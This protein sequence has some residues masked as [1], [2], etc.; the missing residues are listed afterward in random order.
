MK[1]N[2]PAADEVRV[3]EISRAVCAID[4]VN[5]QPLV[6]LIVEVEGKTGSSP[7]ST[8]PGK[9][10]NAWSLL[11]SAAPGR[12]SQCGTRGFLGL[13]DNPQS[14]GSPSRSARLMAAPSSVGPAVFLG[15]APTRHATKPFDGTTLPRGG[16]VSAP[17]A[18]MM[19]LVEHP[20][21]P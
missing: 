9:Y 13:T 15:S 20:T 18:G 17:A 1:Y 19:C 7:A 5:G 14:T 3:H 4:T 16:G 2:T 12:S 21:P 11:E 10:L 6:D 8:G